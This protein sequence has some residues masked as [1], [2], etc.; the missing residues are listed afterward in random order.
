MDFICQRQI[1]FAPRISFAE[2]QISSRACSLCIAGT[3]WSFSPFF[4][5]QRLSVQPVS[6]R[7]SL[8]KIFYHNKREMSILFYSK[9]QGESQ[10]GSGNNVPSHLNDL[11][12][13]KGREAQRGVPKRSLANAT[14]PFY[15]VPGG[16]YMP[17]Y[18][19]MMI[20]VNTEFWGYHL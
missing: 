12:C 1:S 10:R 17:T 13:K 14:S 15:S 5:K 18:T 3:L 4:T 19:S 20:D 2:R 8:T 11:P 6:I 9:K 16:L 7:H